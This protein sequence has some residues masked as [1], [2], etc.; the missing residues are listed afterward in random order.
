[1]SLCLLVCW[2]IVGAYPYKQDAESLISRA[3][4]CQMQL[5]RARQNLKVPAYSIQHGDSEQ[6]KI[7]NNIKGEPREK[8]DHRR[9]MNPGAEA[10]GRLQSVP[11]LLKVCFR[12]AREVAFMMCLRK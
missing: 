10:G 2:K 11:Q 7:T 3:L 9:G 4:I 1:M 8:T 12:S 6:A 5:L